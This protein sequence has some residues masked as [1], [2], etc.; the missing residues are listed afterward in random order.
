MASQPSVGFAGDSCEQ[1]CGYS[2]QPNS[3]APATNAMAYLANC[4]RDNTFLSKLAVVMFDKKGFCLNGQH[5]LMALIAW[6]N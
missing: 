6:F 1:V 5:T 3:P 2:R 4:M